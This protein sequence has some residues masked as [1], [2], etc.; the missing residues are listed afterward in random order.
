MVYENTGL[1]FKRTNALG[2]WQFCSLRIIKMIVLNLRKCEIKRSL[3]QSQKYTNNKT[4][5]KQ[6]KQ[7]EDTHNEKTLT[8]KQ[9][10]W[11]TNNSSLKYSA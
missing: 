3:S 10:G 8:T 7:H 6:T 1:Q 2:I 11:Y 5:Q 9:N 4:T